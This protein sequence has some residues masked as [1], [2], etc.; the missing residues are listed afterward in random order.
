MLTLSRMAT[1]TVATKKE[2]TALVSRLQAAN[3]AYHNSDTLLMSDAEYDAGLRRLAELSPKHPLLLKVGATAAGGTQL[4]SKMASL[5]KVHPDSQGGGGAV[6]RWV[7]KQKGRGVKAIVVM[8]KLDGLSALWWGGKKKL[9]LRGDGVKG[10]DVSAAVDTFLKKSDLHMLEGADE[11][12]LIRGELVLPEARTPEG[13]IGR[14]LVNGWIHRA[15][16]GEKVAELQT[17]DFVAYQVI[18]SCPMTRIQQVNWL[19]AHKFKTPRTTIVSI[20][21]AVDDVFGKILESWK[22]SNRVYPIDG[23]VIGAGDISAEAVCS[24][25]LKNPS[26]AVAFKMIVDEQLRTTRVVG[27]LWAASPQGYLIPRIQIE[28]VE[29]SGAKIEFCSGHNARAIVSQGIGAGAEIRMRRSG[30]VIPTLDAVLQAAPGGAA[31][32]AEG[33]WEWAGD[34]TT[35]THIRVSSES[36]EGAKEVEQRRLTH[37]IETLG[38]VGVG[39]GIV[40]KL[41]KDGLTT[42]KGVWGASVETLRGILGEGRGKLVWDAL[43]APSAGWKEINFLI[44]SAR[45][46]RGVGERKLDVLFKK[47]P[48]VRKWKRDTVG[49]VE[50]WTSAT[51]D[52]LFH[53]L[54]DA[55]AWRER[56]FEWVPFRVSEEVAAAPAASAGTVVFS[57]ARSKTLEEKMIAAGWTIGDSIT[58]ATTMLVVKST[59]TETG[60]TAKARSLGIQ[61]RSLDELNAE[62]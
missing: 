19:S 25:R 8:E 23:I 34:P 11:N 50:G 22:M 6:R 7:E 1:A 21:T 47:E 28:P 27:V 38:V 59:A 60:K 12:T 5:N 15:S 58:K 42:P 41:V 56:E 31:M 20:G 45:L 48:D 29:I 37:V 36:K 55:L 24:E 54:P 44:A 26:D 49:K 10:V 61:I 33:T 43:R 57:G 51:L 13:S 16:R 14:S 32:P 53:V 4:P 2:L 9:Y 17:V 46:P 35:A 3:E 39:P 18:S 30:D 40:A 62:F 52:E